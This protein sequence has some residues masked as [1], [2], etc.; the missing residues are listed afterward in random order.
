MSQTSINNQNL[1]VITGGPGAG[2][3]S[4]LRELAR[5]GLICV[6]EVARQIIQEQVASQGD[7]VPWGNT[8]RYVEIMLSRSIAEFTRHSGARQPTFFD[9][10]IPDVLCYARLIDL[11]PDEIQRACNG[12]RYNRLVFMAPPWE[13]IYTMDA[14]RK[15]TFAEAIE[16][17]RVMEQSYR[18][19]AYEVVELPRVSAERRAEFVLR[20]ISAKRIGT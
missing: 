18:D 12:Y 6:P 1:Y 11:Q 8:A 3:T 13:E 20:Q 9:R 15:Q 7:A 10:G 19:C 17:H 4:L 14:E 16:T 2:K 5:R